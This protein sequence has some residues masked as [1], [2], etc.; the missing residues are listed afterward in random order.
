MLLVI[1]DQELLH[2]VWVS[3]RSADAVDINEKRTVKSVA[4]LETSQP[5]NRVVTEQA[6]VAPKCTF[7]VIQDQ[8]FMDFLVKSAFAAHFS[9]LDSK[10]SKQSAEVATFLSTVH[11]YR[12]ELTVIHR[13]YPKLIAAFRPLTA[14]L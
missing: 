12:S 13:E 6:D 4:L 5:D 2:T 9:P 1:F 10:R 11:L 8:G 3:V 7:A 14:V